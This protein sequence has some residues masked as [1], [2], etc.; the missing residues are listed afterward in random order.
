M[1]EGQGL[2]VNSLCVRGP[3]VNFTGD[4]RKVQRYTHDVNIIT[5]S[6][7]DQFLKINETDSKLILQVLMEVIVLQKGLSAFFCVHFVFNLVYP[8]KLKQCFMFIEEY[9]FDI[10]Q[11]KKTMDYRKGVKKLFS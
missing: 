5:S 1:L 8:K 10:H 2:K 3:R 9:L 7:L 6:I 4:V 11:K